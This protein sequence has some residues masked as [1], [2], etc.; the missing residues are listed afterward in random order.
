MSAEDRAESGRLAEAI[1][2]LLPQLEE[3]GRFDDPNRGGRERSAV[4]A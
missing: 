1:E 3:F 2:R 4:T